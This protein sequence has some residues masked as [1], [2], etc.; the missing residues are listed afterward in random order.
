MNVERGDPLESGVEGLD[1]LLREEV[2]HSN[3]ALSLRELVSRALHVTD[4]GGTYGDEELRSGRVESDALD[5]SL[6]LLERRLSLMLC[7]LMNKDRS[8]AR[9]VRQLISH[10]PFKSTQRNLPSEAT[11]EK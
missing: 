5:V 6:L 4:G 7:E 3:V 9:C 2:V 11:V 1:E 10:M 8:V